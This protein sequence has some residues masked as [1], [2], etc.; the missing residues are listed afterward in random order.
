MLGDLRTAVLYVGLLAMSL[1]LLAVGGFVQFDD[2]SGDGSN[3]WNL[4]LGAIAVVGPIGA[5]LVAWKDAKARVWLGVALGVLFG[6]LLWQKIANDGFRFIWH[7]D[8]GELA[9]LTVVVVLVAAVL[10]ATGVQSKSEPA[11]GRWLVRAAIYLCGCAVLVLV[12]VVA[13]TA[14]Y[15]AT[16]CENA[17][18]DCLS[19]LGGMAWGVFSLP[20]AAVAIVVIEVVLQ[21]GRKRRRAESGET[22]L[23]NRS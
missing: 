2:F 3:E 14:Y 9:Q 7:Q 17:D 20:V 18:P 22:A 16:D 10:V 5:V 4:P 6:F 15:N 13:G 21:R 12:A 11:A 23:E 19:L 1:V 8:E